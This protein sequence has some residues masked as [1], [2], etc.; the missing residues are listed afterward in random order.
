MDASDWVIVLSFAALIPIFVFATVVARRPRTDDDGEGETTAVRPA[1]VARRAWMR[2]IV[3]DTVSN[4]PGAVAFPGGLRFV[5]RGLPGRVDLRA[6]E[7]EIHLETGALV[8]QRVEVV[9]NGFPMSLFLGPEEHRLQIR[10]PRAEYTRIFRSRAEEQVLKEIGVPF[11]L[12]LRPGAMLLRL[13]ARPQ[14]GASLRYWM[15]CAFRIVDLLPGIETVSRVQVAELVH[16]IADDTVCQVCG[17]SLARGTV[18]RCAACGTPHHEDCWQY[19]RKCS[20]FGCTSQRS[21]P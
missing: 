14:N 3:D 10:G 21:V 18:V 11:D 6:K 15:G 20:T 2:Q 19:T 12:S 1:V 17:S 4:L 7:T 8:Q 5:H 13:G 9:T 16:R